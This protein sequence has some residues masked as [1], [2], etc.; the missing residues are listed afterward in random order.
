[1]YSLK[2]DFSGILTGSTSLKM[3]LASPKPPVQLSKEIAISNAN[4]VAEKGLWLVF[5]V[6][7]YGNNSFLAVCSVGSLMDLRNY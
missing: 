4:S 5:C 1:M 7:S 6:K 3:F 2:S